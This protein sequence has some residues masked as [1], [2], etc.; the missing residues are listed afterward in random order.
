MT[1]AWCWAVFMT[2]WTPF[3]ALK[4]WLFDR[5]PRFSIALANCCYAKRISTLWEIDR[6]QSPMPLQQHQT[7]DPRSWCRWMESLP[8]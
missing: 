1:P 7:N 8:T 3:D 2:P 6:R 4:S 5:T